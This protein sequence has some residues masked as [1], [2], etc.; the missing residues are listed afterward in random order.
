[1]DQYV[2][3]DVSQKLTAICVIDQDGK[4]LWRGNCATSPASIAAV[5]Q[6][7]APRLQRAGMETGPLAVWLYHGLRRL[8][9]PIDC[10]HARHAHA[11]LAS[12][13]NKTDT[14]DA[15]GIAQLTRTGWY[16]PVEIKSMASHEVRLLLRAR[17]KLVGLRTAM[18][19]QIRGTLKTFGVVLA[20]G[21]GL[22]FEQLVLS[23]TPRSSLI[24]HVIHALLDTWRHLNLQIRDF[25]KAIAR[26]ANT[27]HVC[28]RLMT[29]PGVGSLTA[30]AFASAVDDPARF[31]RLQDI[32]PYLGLT[33]KKYQSGDVD[34][35]GSI[36][37][38]GGPMTRQ[39]L[40]EAASILIT[41]LKKECALRQWALE[42]ASRCG[43]RKAT[44]ATARKLATVLLT[45]WRQDKDFVPGSA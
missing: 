41:R 15:H 19:N 4:Q 27:S 6:Q 44:V 9:V 3:L 23:Q 43:L 7:R 30:V 26:L 2:G 25:D 5:L 42:L 8:G 22:T 20:A 31:K 34:R 10:I 29:V 33:P 13:L 18:Y 36:S 39:L 35:Q 1:M 40:F 38:T 21:K 24:Q 11:A 17:H 12:Q 37:K 32:G 28:R 45:L 16:R 14:N